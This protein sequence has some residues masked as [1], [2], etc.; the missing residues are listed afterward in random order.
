MRREQRRRT[1]GPGYATGPVTKPPD[2]HGLVGWDVLFNGMTT[3]LY[4]VAALGE[5]AAP[6][7]FASAAKW[8]YPIALALLV[9]DLA[10]LV[11]DLGDP[12]RFHHM[13][14]VF[15]PSSPMS[16]GVW[17]LNLYA[18]LLTAVVAL[19]LLSG[20]GTL[21]GVRM[22]AL[23]VGLLPA[24]SSAVYKGV[25]FSVSSQPGWRDARWLGGYLTASAFV[26][27]AAEMLALAVL[28]HDEKAA[29]VLR[30]ALGVLLVL[31]AVPLGLLLADLR[32]SGVWTRRQLVVAVSVALGVGMVIPLGLLLAEDGPPLLL[33]AVLF[34]FVGS[35]FLRFRIVQLP[36]RAPTNRSLEDRQTA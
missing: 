11:L 7:A 35:A 19:D 25:L 10:L 30:L 4:L 14:R 17:S 20:G 32:R 27:G 26:L 2:W 33:T 34:A 16:L 23:V 28:L 12:L 36:Q 22:A 15:K 31:H 13:L 21:E 1:A 29:A 18:L 6:A 3:G 8:A 9:I 5:L 24:L